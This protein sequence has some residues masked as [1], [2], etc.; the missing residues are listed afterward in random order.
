MQAAIV[1]PTANEYL[2]YYGKYIE[3]VSEPDVLKVL[4]EQAGEVRRIAASVPESRELY[5]YAPGK[6]SV[7]QVIGHMVDVERIFGYRA[8]RISRRDE[9][10]LS[11]FDENTYVANGPYDDVA[12]RDLAEEFAVVR[13]ANLLVLR[14]LDGAH[15]QLMGTANGAPI[16][17]RALAYILAG[18]VRHHL[19]GLRDN[20]AIA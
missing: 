3:L 9:T 18:H 8:L 16:S 14:R 11:G 10:P 17:V 12:V 2:S 13:A 19:R 20:Y 6:W 4:E 1:R 7:R 5:R 15:A